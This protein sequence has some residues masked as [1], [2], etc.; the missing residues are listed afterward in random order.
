MPSVRLQWR[1][2]EYS[3]EEGVGGIC[4]YHV[5]AVSRR[6]NDEVQ[7]PGKRGWIGIKLPYMSSWPLDE[8]PS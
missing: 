4:M 8:K 7:A 6:V 1:T 2:N 3:K 5:Y